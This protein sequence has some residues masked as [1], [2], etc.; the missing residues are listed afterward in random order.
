MEKQTEAVFFCFTH[1][2]QEQSRQV[3]WAATLISLCGYK[4]PTCKFQLPKKYLKTFHPALST[5]SPHYLKITSPCYC[6]IHKKL[7]IFNRF[8]LTN[9]WRQR[10]IVMSFLQIAFICHTSLAF[11]PSYTPMPGRVRGRNDDWYSLHWDATMSHHHHPL[12]S[13]II[14]YPFS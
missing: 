9:P 14:T 11:L 6:S 2:M 5:L 3:R 10:I 4:L 7:I 8:I 12:S 13:T 1:H